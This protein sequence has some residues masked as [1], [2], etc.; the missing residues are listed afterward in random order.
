MADTVDV[1][2]VKDTGRQRLLHLQARSDGTGEAAV[3]KLD[4]STK[5]TADGQTCTY[6]VIDRIEYDVGGMQIRLDWD[7]DTDDEIVTLSGAGFFDWTY[8]GGLGDPKSAGGTGDI[9]LTSIGAT[10]GDSYDISIWY[11]CKA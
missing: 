11:R 5:L 1:R 10:A 2:A 7:H 4:I 6:T 8:V 9:L 3:T